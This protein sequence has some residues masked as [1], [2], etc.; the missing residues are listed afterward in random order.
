MTRDGCNGDYVMLWDVFS[1]NMVIKDFEDQV[2]ADDMVISADRADTSCI[3]DGS[4]I[5]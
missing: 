1:Y 3:L 4:N 5:L 2:V